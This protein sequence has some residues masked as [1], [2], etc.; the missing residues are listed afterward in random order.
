MMFTI[1]ITEDDESLLGYLKDFLLE[2]GYSVLVAQDGTSALKQTQRSKPD[3]LLLDLKLPDITGE[4][5]CVEV[6]KMYPDLPVIILTAKD[7]T[8]DLVQS[9]H[10]GADDYIAKPFEVDELL[11][12]IKARLRESDHQT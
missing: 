11:A 5:V 6:K 7:T 1:L 2:Q 4:T 3:L 12:R 10:I 9:L 8:Q